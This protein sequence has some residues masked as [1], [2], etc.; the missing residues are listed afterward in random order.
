MWLDAG[1]R[2][3]FALKFTDVF[4][5]IGFDPLVHIL[6]DGSGGE[7]K[8]CCSTTW[9]HES[10]VRRSEGPPTCLRCIVEDAAWWR[11]NV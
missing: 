10:T 6:S 3:A 7:W 4:A 2:R 5:V 9:F 11:R 1:E 8:A